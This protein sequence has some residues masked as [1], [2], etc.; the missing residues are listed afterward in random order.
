MP[1]SALLSAKSGA[2]SFFAI[3]VLKSK[4]AEVCIHVDT[5]FL[6]VKPSQAI[7]NRRRRFPVAL[8]ISPFAKRSENENKVES[9]GILKISP[10]VYMYLNVHF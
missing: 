10:L 8:C 9:K 7:N 2:L 3:H 5:G 4:N 6:L 1:L